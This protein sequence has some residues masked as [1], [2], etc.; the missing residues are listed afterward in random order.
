MLITKIRG[1]KPNTDFS[2]A[3]FCLC[4][5]GFPFQRALTPLLAFVSAGM[6]IALYCRQREAFFCLS[7]RGLLIA[8]A[9]GIAVTGIL[10]LRFNLG[11]IESDAHYK[12]ALAM[13]KRHRN[14]E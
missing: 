6:I 8:A 12:R 1:D 2:I 3:I 5:F 14:L 13:E 7:K 4:K 10:L 11:I 9:L